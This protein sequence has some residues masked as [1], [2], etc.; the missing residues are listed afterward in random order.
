MKD[1]R[2][3]IYA[4]PEKVAKLF[5]LNVGTLANWRAKKIGPPYVKVGKKVL[6]RV[7]DVQKWLQTLE[8]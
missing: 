6:Y 7:L 5:G 2:N 3:V 1:T 8:K 4:N